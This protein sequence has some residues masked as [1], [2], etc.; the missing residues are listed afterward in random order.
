MRFSISNPAGAVLLSVSIVA[1]MLG[2]V[3]S[4]SV[5]LVPLEEAFHTSRSSVSLTYSLALVSITLAVFFGHRV[6]SR[7]SAAHLISATCLLASMGTLMSAFAPA[8]AYVWLGYGL[9]FGVA[10]GLGYAFGLQIAAQLNP[11]REGI[12]MG[13]V[14]A[15]Y[16]LG[17]TI[18]PAIFTWAMSLD[19]FR[20]AMLVLSVSL[21]IGRRIC[22]QL[23][24]RV[25]ARFEGARPEEVRCTVLL[26]Q[27]I[28]LWV[29]Y[30]TAVAGG[31]I[32][33]G[34]AAEISK[35][36]GFSAAHWVT[37]AIVSICGMA[38]SFAGGWLADHVTSVK[39]LTYLPMISATALMVLALQSNIVLLLLCLGMI[40]F[41]Y[42]AI[43]TA[44]P[45][46]ITQMFGIWNSPRIY[47]RIFTAWGAAGFLG[48][49]L[50]GLLFDQTGTYSTALA[51]A[52]GFGLLSSLAI[53]LH[54]FTVKLH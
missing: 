17:S 1:M 54:D 46:T 34:H 33:F 42:G 28:L 50:A 31:L 11:G 21:L 32:V 23:L 47:G 2:S 48:P 18:S 45:A 44:Y 14:T 22:V 13:I 40:G 7:W 12:S 8:L 27:Y 53:A 4:F 5:F 36:H 35:T 51:V 16:A 3:H 24:H 9:L 43:V 38:G 26:R 10:N 6:F 49:W 41:I 52:I 15:S 25:N 19:G 29:G 30:G 39:L 37:P 20:S